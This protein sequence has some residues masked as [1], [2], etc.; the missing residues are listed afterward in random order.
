MNQAIV[1]ENVC[2]TLD[3]AGHGLCDVCAINRRHNK[4]PV[5]TSFTHL[6]NN[7]NILIKELGTKS[8]SQIKIATTRMSNVYAWE[9]HLFAC[10]LIKM[11]RK[12]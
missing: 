8:R 2:L 5:L 7:K 1:D 10:S 11:S 6:D 9:I 12:V 3:M 4:F